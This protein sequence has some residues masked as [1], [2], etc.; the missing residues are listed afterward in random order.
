MFVGDV[1]LSEE[2]GSR[3][4]AVDRASGSQRWTQVFED[5]FNSSP[6]V[7]DDTVYIGCD[8][9][10]VYA[11][12]TA[13]G[14]HRWAFDAHDQ[15]RSSPSVVDG[16]V[17]VGS[18][19]RGVYAIDA[20]TG[21]RQWCYNPGAGGIRSSPTVADNTVYVGTGVF[22]EAIDAGAGEQLWQFETD[23]TLSSSP[24]VA[25]STVYVGS[26]DKQLYAVDPA[27]GTEN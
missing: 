16:T 6:T 24:A 18:G 5:G 13:T 9:G 21:T 10:H 25:G 11:L 22:L 20:R 3:F 2:G 12:D 4:Y 1:D 17:Y 8:D 23:N 7:V 26:W 14:E 19:S 15:V 27:T